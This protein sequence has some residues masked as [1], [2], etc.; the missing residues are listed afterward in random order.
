[1]RPEITKEL[2][3]EW[4]RK[5]VDF[6]Q[7]HFLDLPITPA[8][9]G[10]FR[11]AAA[12][13]EKRTKTEI[14]SEGK[15]MNSHEDLPPAKRWQAERAAAGA[16]WLSA[17]GAPRDLG[18]ELR[19]HDGLRRLMSDGRGTA[20]LHLPLD[21]FLTKTVVSSSGVSVQP[22]RMP[23]IIAEP[24][25]QLRV[26][27]LLTTVPT[28]SNL[29][30]WIDV[31]SHTKTA[32]PVA[33]ASDKPEAGIAFTKREARVRTIATWIPASKQIIED[34]V[35]LEA[36]LRSSLVYAVEEE[37]EDQL[38][39]GSGAGENLHGLV[40]QAAV[41][42]TSLLGTNWTRIDVIGRAIQQLAAADELMP[43]F[44]VLNPSDYWSL[45]LTKDA[46]GRYLIANPMDPRTLNTLFGLAVIECSAMAPGQFLLGTSNPAA[47]QIRM[48]Q[49]ITVE[50]STEHADYFTRNLVAIRAEL[51]AALVVMR[52]TAFIKGSLTSSP[53]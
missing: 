12:L 19:S 40:T 11:A 24:R 6:D 4:A 53:A 52:P 15:A 50:I 48:R 26:Q 35:G 49:P 16:T 7:L 28:S 31:T 45:A 43:D 27:N 51:R 3:A 13:Q 1:M 14:P 33:E 25:R 2:R 21:G 41:F 29:I 18:A 5:G 34:F 44:V 10:R 36:F 37:F 32:A 42:N 39:F 30:E 9:G 17:G 22:E 8:D 47:A 38:L 23:A 20:V 46:E